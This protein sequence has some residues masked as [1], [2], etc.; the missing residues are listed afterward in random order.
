M[1]V[2]GCGEAPRLAPILA[3]SEGHSG[4]CFL[5]D[6]QAEPA[7]PP[8]AGCCWLEIKPLQIQMLPVTAPGSRECARR[9]KG[10]LSQRERFPSVYPF[11]K[12]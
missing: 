1:G 12:S 3:G 9:K 10:C 8:A 2:Q 6:L 5:D 7:D 4:R 11:N